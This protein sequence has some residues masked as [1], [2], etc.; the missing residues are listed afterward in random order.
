MNG[1]PI[2]GRDDEVIK[3]EGLGTSDIFFGT[4]NS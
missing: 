1:I 2:T 3:D 4:R